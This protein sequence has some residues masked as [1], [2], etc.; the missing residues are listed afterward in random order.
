[1]FPILAASLSLF[2]SSSAAFSDSSAIFLSH[3]PFFSSSS[4]ASP[5]AFLMVPIS[6]CTMLTSRRADSCS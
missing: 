2:F 1:M 4:D 6:F 5:L 3:T